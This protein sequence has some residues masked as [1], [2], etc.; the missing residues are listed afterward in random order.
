MARTVE[1]IYNSMVSE[2]QTFTQLTGLMPTYNLAGPN[3]DNPFRKLLD[4]INNNSSVGIWRQAMLL[5]AFAIHSFEKLQDIFKTDIEQLAKESI[6]GNVAWYAAQVKLWQFGYSLIW[7]NTTFRYYYSDTT[8]A[9]AIA[10]RLVAKVSVVEL[11]GPDTSAVHIKVA[12]DNNGTLIPLDDSPGSELES[13]ETYVNRIKFAGVHTTVISLP[14][15]KVKLSLRRFYD[16]TLDLDTVKAEDE[17]AI[18]D[19][20]KNIDFNGTLYLNDLIDAF[21]AL[22][23]SKEPSLM[24]VSCLCRA[25]AEPAFTAV[26]ESY[27]PASGYF[28]LVPIGNTPGVDT[29]IEYI[30]L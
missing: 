29:Y 1:V 18:K 7:N 6:A 12:K 24:V 22:S 9:A 21:Q 10:A 30:A 3:P 25:D 4:E 16:G 27:N 17:T 8:S 23:S 2:K 14:A 5:V 19:F 28:E 13:L 15:D 20:L 26:T 11:F